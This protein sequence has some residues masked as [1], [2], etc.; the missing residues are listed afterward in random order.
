MPCRPPGSSPGATATHTA[1]RAAWRDRA[2]LTSFRSVGWLLRFGAAE[3]GFR[4]HCAGGIRTHGLELMRLA[5]T[6]AP[7]PRYV[8]PAGAGASRAL[9]RP[10]E[11][12]RCF[13]SRSPT[14]RPW[15]ADRRLRISDA[16]AVLRGGALEPEPHASRLESRRLK[17]TLNANVHFQ[18]ARRRHSFSLR[19]GLESISVFSS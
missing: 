7:L 8:W 3:P 19:R 1:A 5:R 10:R 11:A 14:L 12:G 9:S 18:R 4:L 13:P 15:I 17:P 6:A 2:L 16:V